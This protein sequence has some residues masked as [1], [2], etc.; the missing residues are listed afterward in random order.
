MRSSCSSIKSINWWRLLPEVYTIKELQKQTW[1]MKLAQVSGA[2]KLLT[3]FWLWWNRVYTPGFGVNPNS[4]QPATL[5]LIII[6]SQ[7]L[8]HSSRE[9]ISFTSLLMQVC[10]FFSSCTTEGVFVS[11][12]PLCSSSSSLVALSYN[13]HTF[14]LL[15]LWG[16]SV[17]KIYLPRDLITA[18]YLKIA[19]TLIS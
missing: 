8:S 5:M 18:E 10:I 13:T 15:S 12:V 19:H 16:P 3:P 4:G 9:R 14:A 2:N 1:D 7:I 17:I 6:L 11:P